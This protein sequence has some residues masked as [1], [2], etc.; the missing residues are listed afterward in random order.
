MRSSS[1]SLT[2]ILVSALLLFT[3]LSI[4]ADEKRISVYSTIANYSLSTVDRQGR[5]YVGLLE[6]LEPLGKVNSRSDGNR[7]KIRFGSVD[8]EFTTGKTRGKISG[9]DADLAAPFLLENGRGMIPLASLGAILPRFL[10][11]PVNFHENTRRLFVGNF[12]T[13]FTVDFVKTTPPRLVFNFGN[14]VNP[15]ISTEPGHLRM[16]FIRDPVVAT[17]AQDWKFEDHMITSVAY[18]EN[19]GAAE[20]TVNSTVSLMASF[21][22]GGRTITVMVPSGA[23]W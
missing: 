23:C 13:P 3:V 21:S 14:V 19:N 6:I 20:I 12:T 2:L 15:T 1:A 9:R 10:G 4:S 5:D 8:G 11:G 16:V 18:S 7:W 22:A 17:T